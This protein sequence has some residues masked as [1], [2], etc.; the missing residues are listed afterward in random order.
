[1]SDS[2]APFSKGHPVLPLSHLV[3]EQGSKV[4]LVSGEQNRGHRGCRTAGRGRRSPGRGGKVYWKGQGK[5]DKGTACLCSRMVG[6]TASGARPPGS[7]FQF[8][9]GATGVQF[10]VLFFACSLDGPGPYQMV[11]IWR[12][13]CY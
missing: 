1:M 12:N 2:Q 9:L 8:K 6:G 10:R 7:K 3:T 4:K 13:Q 5:A 11:V